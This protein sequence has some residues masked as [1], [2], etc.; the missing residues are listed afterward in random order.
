MK[1]AVCDESFN[2]G[3]QC[4]V[5]KKHLDFGCAN[6]SEAG[7]RKLGSDRRTAWKCPQC[8]Q[9]RLSP[10]PGGDPSVLDNIL[11]ELRGLKQQLASLP[12]LIEDVKCIKQELS[13]LKASCEFSSDWLDKQEVRLSDLEQKVSD[14]KKIEL[15]M[16]SAVNEISILRKELVQR[17]QWN[18][19]NNIEI[20]GVPV[21]SSENLF[22]I[23]EALTETVAYSFPITQLIISQEYPCR[24][25]RTNI[26]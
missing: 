12:T 9:S 10:V 18:R 7:Y 8:K 15:S 21:K 17:D 23:V 3:V 6:I 2:D 14:V 5:C 16:N 25:L 20:K 11:T 22:S 13:D 24:I 1:C 4:G 19:L 26:L